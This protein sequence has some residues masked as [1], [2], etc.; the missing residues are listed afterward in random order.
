MK[1]GWDSSGAHAPF[2]VAASRKKV[3]GFGCYDKCVTHTYGSVNRKKC[4]DSEDFLVM[5]FLLGGS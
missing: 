5:T 3:D 2:C 1:Y 4:V